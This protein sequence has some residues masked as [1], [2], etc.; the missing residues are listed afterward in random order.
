M[1]LHSIRRCEISLVALIVLAAFAGRIEAQQS[2]HYLQG[3]SGLDNGTAPPPGV[4]VSF[5]PWVNTAISFQGPRG[6]TIE[7]LGLNIGVHN[8]VIQM[9]TRKKFLGAEYGFSVIVSV[10]NP[11]VTADT[12]NPSVSKP[13]LSDV[14]VSPVTLGWEKGNANYLLDYGFYAP[15][16]AFDPSKS[17]NPGLGF[18]EHQIQA[19]MSYSFDKKKLWNASALSTWEINQSKIGLNLKPGPM[20]NLEYS[21]GRRL[22]KHRIN[23]GTAGYAYTKLSPDSGADAIRLGSLALD[24]SFGLGPEFKYTRADKHIGFLLRYERQFAV[25][26]KTQG[27]VFV[28]GVTWVNVFTPST[29]ES[30]K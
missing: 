22:D 17:L 9:T 21:L 7:N 30:H 25:E 1:S 19:G 12:P 2:G 6:N 26:S 3:I 27:N 10:V 14:F 13:G 18:W 20:F 23:L 16:G 28:A 4:Y 11:R 8:A 29:P 15:T 5:L 24:R